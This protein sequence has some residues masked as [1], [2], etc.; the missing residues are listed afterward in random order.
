[1]GGQGGELTSKCVPVPCLRSLNLRLSFI[2]LVLGF[3]FRPDNQ[4]TNK[5]ELTS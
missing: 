2:L 3:S 5:F 4:L 1:M